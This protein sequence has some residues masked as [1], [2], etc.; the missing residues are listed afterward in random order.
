MPEDRIQQAIEE[1]LTLFHSGVAHQ[2][3]GDYPEAEDAYRR[4]LL[5]MRAI[6]NTNGEAATLHYLGTLLE[7][8]GAFHEAQT[9]FEDSYQLFQ[10]ENDAQ[11]SLFSL[12]FQ[13]M[14]ALKLREHEKTSQL[15]NGALDQA[16]SMGPKLIQE[17]WG[18]ARQIA[19][20]LFARKDFLG[21][22]QFGQGMERV[23]TQ[24]QHQ[25]STGTL[26]RKLAELT[27][28][29]GTF[30][31]AC[32]RLWTTQD[33]WNEQQEEDLPNWLLQAAVN[34]DHGTGSGFSF[35]DLA[36]K[37]IQERS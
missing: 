33:D 28:Q 35:T 29:Q 11:N 36:A 30:Y 32:G 14:L 12:F 8:K 27:T 10:S 3:K 15:L 7:S 6:R 23:G 5:M 1:A 2:N 37:V 9:C 13:S 21:L 22:I 26:M 16:F 24:Q 20:V 31:L 4:C 19:G 18:R 25:Q 17:A 34:L